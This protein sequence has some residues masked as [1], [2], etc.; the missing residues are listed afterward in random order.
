[1]TGDSATTPLALGLGL[2]LSAS[3]AQSA[4]FLLQHIGARERPRVTPRHPLVTLRASFTSRLW[5]LGLAAGSAGFLLHLTALALAPLS[6]VQAFVAGGLA[7]TAPL[8]A[9][10]FGH[11]LTR[12]EWR[13][14]ALM[15]AALTVL[16]IG[17]AQQ[18][19]HPGFDAGTLGLY[20]GGISL[21]TLIVAVL[22]ERGFPAILGL[23][24]GSF[25]GVL[26]TSL[27]AL[28]DLGHR[29]GL[30]AALGSPW[31]LVAIA[32]AVAAFFS[33]QRALQ[34]GRALPAIAL[35]EA[36]A[37]SISITAG[38]VAFGDAIGASAGLAALHAAAFLAVVVAAWSLAPVQERVSESAG[39]NPNDRLDLP[40]GR[41]GSGRFGPA[42]S[43]EPAARV[44]QR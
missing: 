29:D 2:A 7:L 8:A 14:V 36:G 3:V 4:G 40:E 32:A 24:A 30:E 38:F 22:S 43:E 18:G 6:L 25:Y 11:R 28:T 15:A 34:T 17:A 12:T 9:F 44:A 27:K 39:R 33:F 20:L 26:D 19:H 31:L 16:P 1:V 23:A 35:M 13:S 10:G 41:G 5:L 42:G 37:E 21:I